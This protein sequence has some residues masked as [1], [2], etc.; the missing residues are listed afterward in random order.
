[1]LL[2]PLVL[3]RIVFLFYST[4]LLFRLLALEVFSFLVLAQAALSTSSSMPR[5]IIVL[6]LFSVFVIEGVIALSGL[7][8]LVTSTGSDCVGSSALLKL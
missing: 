7:V 8:S 2:F 3:I 5:D 6:C 4:N 1:M